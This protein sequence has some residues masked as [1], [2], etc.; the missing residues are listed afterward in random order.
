[1]RLAQAAR[2]ASSRSATPARDGSL[3]KPRSVR[4]CRQTARE[5][6]LRGRRT[7]DKCWR[8]ITC[9]PEARGLSMARRSSFESR[10]RRIIRHAGVVTVQHLRE[11]VLTGRGPMEQRHAGPDLHGV[12]RP[13]D[14]LRRSSLDRQARVRAQA[15]LGPGSGLARARP[16]SDPADNR[17]DQGSERSAIRGGLIDTGCHAGRNEI[18]RRHV[19]VIS[20]RPIRMNSTR[21][22]GTLS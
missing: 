7:T 14:L 12:D 18:A 8:P 22:S 15:W 17:R 20:A 19:L 10:I 11:H 13:E 1:M 6:S 4:A 2:I 9:Q 16:R 3:P 21:R 5:D